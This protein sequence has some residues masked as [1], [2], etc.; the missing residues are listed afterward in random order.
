[1]YE[2]AKAAGI[3]VKLKCFCAARHRSVIKSNTNTES[4][5]AA[6]NFSAAAGN[7]HNNTHDTMKHKQA[8]CQNLS[9]VWP[10]RIHIII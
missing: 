9:G 8:V 7:I 10:P 4:P 3:K 6:G 2:D 1:M 5:D